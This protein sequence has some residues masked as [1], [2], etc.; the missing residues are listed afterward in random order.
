MDKQR[1]IHKFIVNLKREVHGL[2]IL[3]GGRMQDDEKKRFTDNVMARIEDAIPLEVIQGGLPN[4]EL[5]SS[6]G[7]ETGVVFVGPKRLPQI[8]IKNEGTSNAPEG[9]QIIDFFRRK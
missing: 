7:I 1:R 3:D 5:L 9:A 8:I 2:K 4:G 6:R